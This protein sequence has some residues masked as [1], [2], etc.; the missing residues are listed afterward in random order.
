MLMPGAAGGLKYGADPGEG[1]GLLAAA[2]ARMPLLT[3]L[4]AGM[5]AP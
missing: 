2:D 1:A 4:P 3:A 5:R